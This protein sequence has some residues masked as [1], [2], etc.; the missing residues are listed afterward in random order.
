MAANTLTSLAI[1]KVNIDQGHDY[2]DYIR[3]FVLQILVDQNLDV[4]TSNSISQ[5]LSEQFGLEVPIRTVDIVLRRISRSL[6]IKRKSGVYRKI[7]ELPDPQIASKQAKAERQIDAVLNGL[8]Q[9]SQDTSAPLANSGEA[10]APICAFLSEFAITCLR[11][12]L[13]GTAIPN[14]D[15]ARRSDIVLVG[16]Y[17]HHVRESDPERFDGFLI[18]V[19][20]HMLANA[21]VC[22]DLINC[23]KSYRNVSFYLDTPLLVHR[24][25]I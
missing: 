16:N 17:V 18:L 23:P 5:Y 20:G 7:G 24:L 2:L 11:A 1:L 6:P 13:R 10:V 25:G 4:I 15:R 8:Y 21:L 22:P 12:Q 3:P 9:F 14:V 19:R